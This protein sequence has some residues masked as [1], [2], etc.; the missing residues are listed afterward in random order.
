MSGDVVL[1]AAS[2]LD[3][4]LLDNR[5]MLIRESKAQL[6]QMLAVTG[7]GERIGLGIPLP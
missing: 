3:G 7:A 6:E 1:D 2:G 5:G 4:F